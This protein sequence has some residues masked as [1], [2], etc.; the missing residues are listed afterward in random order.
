MVKFFKSVVRIQDEVGATLEHTRKEADGGGGRLKGMNGRTWPFA[1][2]A[3]YDP[4]GV[5]HCLA[6]GIHQEAVRGRQGCVLHP[7]LF[8]GAITPVARVVSGQ[9]CHQEA[10]A[11]IFAGCAL[12]HSPQ[13]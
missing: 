2:C 7:L 4:H 12:P 8:W 3:C 10:I 5:N 13:A 6:R 1:W 9:S 11:R